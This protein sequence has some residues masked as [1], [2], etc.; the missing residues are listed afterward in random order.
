[1]ANRLSYNEFRTKLKGGGYSNAEQGKLWQEYKEGSFTIRD[2]KSHFASR[3]DLNKTRRTKSPR[4]TRSPRRIRSPRRTRSPCRTVSPRRV[5][6]P[7]RTKSPRKKVRFTMF[8]TEERKKIKGDYD[9]IIADARGGKKCIDQTR[10]KIIKGAK[11]MYIYPDIYTDLK[12]F[13][14]D[15]MCNQITESHREKKEPIIHEDSIT[16]W[17][18][19]A[20][21][22][23]GLEVRDILAMKPGQKTKVILL[24]RNVGDYMNDNTG[25]STGKLFDPK[26]EGFSY[27]VYTHHKGLSG[28]L[29]FV[30]IEVVHEDFTWQVNLEAIKDKL[31]GKSMCKSMFWG[32]IPESMTYKELPLGLK[33]GWRGP[34][35]KLKDAD[36]L[37]SKYRHYDTWWDDY[38]PNRIHDY[39]R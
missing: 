34:A 12:F 35:I 5:T 20:A 17:G 23:Y 14:N 15:E 11:G 38:L 16:A 28:R 4:R 3:G 25:K 37:P 18:N 39:G 22:E 8:T 29:E 36:K 33:V 2:T 13:S 21:E 31:E 9:D 7:R 24:D 19:Q 10:K 32:C 26:K 1:M 27:A 30:N 6:S